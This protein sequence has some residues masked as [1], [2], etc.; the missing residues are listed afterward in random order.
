M[1]LNQDGLETLLAVCDEQSFTR[2]AARLQVTTGAVSQRI[3]ALERAVGHPVVDR[4]QPPLPTAVGRELLR[5]ARQS[6][7][8]HQETAARLGDVLHAAEPRIRVALAV[9]ADSLSTWFQPVVAGLARRGDL[10][11]D[12]RIADQDRTADLLRSG[13]VLAAVT[14][15]SEPGPGC[16]SEWLGSMRY[17]PV[18]A[19]SLAPPRGRSLADH[20]GRTAMLQ[21]DS[22]D[23]LPLQ[24][25]DQVGATDVPPAHFVPS[26]R[27][28]FDAVRLGLGWSVLPE[29]QVGQALTDGDLVL[30]DRRRHVDV[31]LW[32]QRWR[33]DSSTIDEVTTAVRAAARD[34]LRGRPGRGSSEGQPPP[35]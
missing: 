21:F 1:R 5:L 18:C 25:L 20:L 9:N 12:L 27:E 32:W 11:L 13:S 2:A 29:G 24:F 4:G 26:N 28:Y 34:G 6:L 35:R 33:I 7:L 14:T 10:L 31:G 3:A 19:P 17:L 30:L 23:R 22:L 16:R 15:E 8:L